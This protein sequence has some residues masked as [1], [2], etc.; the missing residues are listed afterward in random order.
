VI[1][2]IQAILVLLAIQAIQVILVLLVILVIQALQV[3]RVLKAIRDLKATRGRLVPQRILV[4]QGQQV[5]QAI[6]AHHPYGILRVNGILVI[7][8]ILLEI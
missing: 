2:E 5:E 3:T 4:Q 7:L 1:L 8:F 6:Q